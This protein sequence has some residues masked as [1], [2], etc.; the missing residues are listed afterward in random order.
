MLVLE[1]PPVH[2]DTTSVTLLLNVLISDRVA[3]ELSDVFN[4]DTHVFSKVLLVD[5]EQ[6]ATQVVLSL[7]LRLT[8]MTSIPLV[9]GPLRTEPFRIFCIG[10]SRRSNFYLRLQAASELIQL[11]FIELED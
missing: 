1:V 5:R 10:S 6:V 4:R 3:E 2:S 9:L 11:C 7:M 8:V